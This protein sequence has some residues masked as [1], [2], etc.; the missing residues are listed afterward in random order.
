MSR[1]T[2]IMLVDNP[3]ASDSRV[4]KEAISFVE[5]G[6]EVIIYCEK[7]KL[8]PNKESRNGFTI[9]RLFDQFYE[10]P[11]DKNF[12]TQIETLAQVIG[13]LHFQFLHCHD[14]KLL[15]LAERIKEL[16]SEVFFTYDSH[17]YLKGWPYYREIPSAINRF[18]GWLVWRKFLK[19]EKKAVQKIN[20][21]I[22]PSLSISEAQKKWFKIK[23]NGI[24]IRNIPWFSNEFKRFE[25]KK[26]LNIN[27]TEILL[28]HSGSIYMPESFISRLTQW[29]EATQGIHLLFVGNRP[30][31]IKLKSAHNTSKSIHFLD[32][33]NSTLQSIQAACDVGII[34]TRSDEYEA[35]QLGSS[36]KLM[37]FSLV[38]IPIIGTDQVAHR[39]MSDQFHHME[40]YSPND[41]ESFKS[42]IQRMIESL[43]EKKKNAE[44]IKY[45]LSWEDEFRPVVELYKKVAAR[46]A[47]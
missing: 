4:E 43:P 14:F 29:V 11:Y 17:E 20:C 2:I 1:A 37:E 5:S 10:K 47:Q 32:Y 9:I 26:Q 46:A 39:E 16:K 36:N 45:S 22:T 19:N 15:P 33:D 8:L 34:Y 25:L 18:K 7:S 30:I 21:L 28:V 42:A 31:H 6:F 40:L 24:A 38:G 13:Q 23:I 35:H 3:L 27:S 44:R 41:F 12:H